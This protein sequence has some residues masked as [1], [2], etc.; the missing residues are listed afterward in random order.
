MILSRNVLLKSI[1]VF[2]AYNSF[3]YAGLTT[4]KHFDPSPR[5]SAND[6][7]VPLG[8]IFLDLKQARIKH[9]VPS[10][11]RVVNINV[12]GFLQRAV[13]A[14]GYNGVNEYGTVLG[15]PQGAFEL[16]DFRGTMYAMGLFL[17]YNPHL[18]KPKNI[19]ANGTDNG[20][21]NNITAASIEAFKLPACL[22][23]IAFE[24]A[25]A[26]NPTTG[27]GLV[28]YNGTSTTTIP[29]ST[30]PIVSIFNADALAR[31]TLYFGAFS[32][33]IVYQQ[34]GM[35][36]EISFECSDYIN[37][38]IQG[39]M[40]NMRQKY[41]NTYQTSSTSG[42][43]TYGPYSL[44]N[45][46]QTSGSTS[47][48][49][50]NLYNTLTQGENTVSSFPPD[51]TA[52]QIFDEQISNNIAAIL[53]PYCMGSDPLCGF[54]DYSIDDIR[55]MMTFKKPFEPYRYR[56]G[57]DEDSWPDVIFTPFC[58]FGGS[59]P[60]GKEIDYYNIL[61][62]PFGN[63]GHPS[64]GGGA[65]MTFDFAES[66]EVGFEGGVTTFLEQKECR[67]F[68]TH[69]LQR[70]LYPFTADV[71]TQPGMNWHIRLLLNAYQFIKHVSFW[72]NYEL[73]EHR[74]DKFS[75]CDVTKAEYYVPSVL[76]CRSDWRAQFLNMGLIFD[77]QPGI[78]ASLLW[79]QPIAPRNA[80]YP[81]SILGSVNFLF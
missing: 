26:D 62:L 3:L 18:K 80:Y 59:F 6:S 12:S 9:E 66:V 11:K 16:G 45:W 36:W 52:Q 37:F 68:P 47:S 14:K 51:T 64:I 54:E 71:M 22:E 60:V 73:I 76:T 55:L 29:T 1:L 74:A 25:Q 69:E 65:G 75:I 35:R 79:Q 2:T 33:P 39:G 23:S 67:P 81:V 10:R 31:D 44:S 41:V 56:H 34:A 40:S 43:Q 30:P 5:Y 21:P 20:D 28:F 48:T 32:L 70:I 24:L 17:G 49:I 78:Q 19:W 53:N 42:Q 72:M 63:N 57:D 8:S 50:S 7:G 15:S 77:I 38:I 46:Q 58:W 61:S 13:R 27:K 4:L